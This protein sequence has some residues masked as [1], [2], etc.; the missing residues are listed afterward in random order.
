M[1]KCGLNPETIAKLITGPMEI[2][3]FAMT[4]E[5]AKNSPGFIQ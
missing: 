2:A 1:Q 5:S 3:L 4:P